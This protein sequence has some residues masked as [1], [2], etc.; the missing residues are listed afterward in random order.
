MNGGK[1][2]KVALLAPRIKET[3]VCDLCILQRDKNIDLF[4]D[5]LDDAD[6]KSLY[7][8]I[9]CALLKNYRGLAAT[10]IALGF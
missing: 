4:S 2:G 5:L 6:S 1:R 9:K 8:H 3:T 7:I 10:F